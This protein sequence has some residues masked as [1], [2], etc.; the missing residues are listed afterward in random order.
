MVMAID[1]V[2]AFYLMSQGILGGGGIPLTTFT[3]GCDGGSALGTFEF[4]KSHGLPSWGS[5][6]HECRIK[7]LVLLLWILRGGVG[8]INVP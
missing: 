4:I 5:G 3:S 8:C 7:F 6:K 2:I 1:L